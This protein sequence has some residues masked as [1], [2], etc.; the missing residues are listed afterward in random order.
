MDRKEFITACGC[1]CLGGSALMVLLQSCASMAHFAQTTFEKNQI[2][3]KKNEFV[4]TEKEKTVSRKFVLVNW[5]MSAYPICVYKINEDEYSALFMRCT[6][7][8]CELRPHGNFLS[9]PC[10][11]SEFSNK[12]MVQN[13]PAEQNLQTFKTTTDSEHIYIHV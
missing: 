2:T 5:K 6:H 3:I 7:K 1:A 9:C 12:G 11:G 13:P 10:H 8:A 4:K